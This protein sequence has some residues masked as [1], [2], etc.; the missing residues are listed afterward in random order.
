MGR[1]R[2]ASSLLAGAIRCRTSGDLQQ[3]KKLLTSCVALEPR[4]SHLRSGV[5]LGCSDADEAVR[6]ARFYLALQ[7]C[8]L[9]R[10]E[11]ADQHLAHL[12]LRARLSNKVW[13][14]QF[15]NPLP[16]DF[17]VRVVDNGLPAALV[18][19]ARRAFTPS[20]PY[21]EEHR[22]DDPDLSFYSHAHL[23]GEGFHIV[24]QLIEATRPILAQV[25]PQVAEKLVM[26]EWW[27]HHRRRDQWHGH[28][29][30]FDTDE[31]LLRDT[32]GALIKHPAISS[33]VYLCEETP[34]FGPTLV[35]N[36][37]PRASPGTEYA[38]AVRPLPGRVLFFDGSYLHGALP[39]KPWLADKGGAD[40]RL[41]LMIGWWTQPITVQSPADPPRPMTCTDP[42][43]LW[44]K[45]MSPLVNPPE[46]LQRGDPQEVRSCTPTWA[47][48]N[49]KAEVGSH[50]AAAPPFG[51]FFLT[52]RG[53]IDEDVH[54]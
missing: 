40:T 2:S 38:A 42:E 12:N 50:A 34:R 16:D 24:D 54:N 45:A 36:Q 14:E 30:H 44:V 27:V 7:G 4:R 13:L 15:Q 35:T 19:A 8:Q 21:W 9:G 25:A 29:L 39:G 26:A 51:R 5:R 41:C 22:Y 37:A 23:L 17:F 33:V 53:Q 32:G 18:D 52:H 49:S 11:E 31:Q 28:P 20:S 48:V 46:A 10:F 3:E 1:W 43:A 6:M 47:D